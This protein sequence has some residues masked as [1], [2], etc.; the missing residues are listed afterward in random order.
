MKRG[1]Y[2]RIYNLLCVV[3]ES[4]IAVNK[5]LFEQKKP[6]ANAAQQAICAL[7]PK[8]FSTCFEA[9]KTKNDKMIEII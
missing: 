9:I 5:K 2:N 3:V 6:I 7:M 4:I 1:I 8:S